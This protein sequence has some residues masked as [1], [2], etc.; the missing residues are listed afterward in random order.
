[1]G[2][3]EGTWPWA[4]PVGNTAIFECENSWNPGVTGDVSVDVL[5]VF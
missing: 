4:D 1:M 5:S 2:M 3:G